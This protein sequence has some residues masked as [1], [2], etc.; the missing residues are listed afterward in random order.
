MLRSYGIPF[1]VVVTS[2]ITASTFWDSTNHIN[3]YQFAVLFGANSI[4]DEGTYSP[5]VTSA[6]TAAASNGTNFIF[7]GASITQ[8]GN[9]FFGFTSYLECPTHA[10]A[11]GSCGAETA[12]KVKVNSTFA[13]PTRGDPT[14][15]SGTGTTGVNVPSISVLAAR[16]RAPSAGVKYF[17]TYSVNGTTYPLAIFKKFGSSPAM[18][19]WFGG[20]EGAFTGEFPGWS[21]MF[22][23]NLA[24]NG[25][26]LFKP[27]I[28]LFQ[29][30][31]NNVTIANSPRMMAWGT[32]GSAEVIRISDHL[33]LT[34]AACNNTGS[35]VTQQMIRNNLPGELDFNLNGISSSVIT[36]ISSTTPVGVTNPQGTAGFRYWG[37]MGG[38][39]TG[40]SNE[41]ELTAVVDNMTATTN[42]GVGDTGSHT[43]TV[44]INDGNT[45][46][47]QKIEVLVTATS[48]PSWTLAFKDSKGNTLWTSPSQTTT[49]SAPTWVKFNDINFSGGLTGYVN[50]LQG[51]DKLVLTASS[52]TVKWENQSS[53]Q[54]NW[55]VTGRSNWD[56][57]YED[58]SGS[59]NFA[60][61]SALVPDSIRMAG[62]SL[63]HSQNKT[64]YFSSIPG[65]VH[66][67]DIAGEKSNI[68]LYRGTTT[69]GTTSTVLQDA[70]ASWTTNQYAGGVLTYTSGPASGQ[71]AAIS[72]NTANTVTTQA[73]GST[74]DSSGDTFLITSP[75]GVNFETFFTPADWSSHRGQLVIQSCK[76]LAQTYHWSIIANGWTHAKT[77]EGSYDN[78]WYMGNGSQAST[79]LKVERYND[80]VSYFNKEFGTN[81]G[82][83][84][85]AYPVPQWNAEWAFGTSEGSVAPGFQELSNGGIFY[86][87]QDAEQTNGEQYGGYNRQSTTPSVCTSVS[88]TPYTGNMLAVPLRDGGKA[89]NMTWAIGYNVTRESNSIVET[90]ADWNYVSSDY[91]L[92]KSQK[93]TQPYDIAS[94]VWTTNYA[95]AKYWNATLDAMID[96]TTFQWSSSTDTITLVTNTG[97]SYGV[98]NAKWGLP[99]VFRLPES[100]QSLGFTSGTDSQSSGSIT[101]STANWRYYQVNV[102]SGL[103]SFAFTYTEPTTSVTVQTSPTLSNA[104]KV[105]YVT[106][107]SPHTFTYY[108][109]SVHNLIAT[110]PIQCGM[111]CNSVFTSWSDSGAVNHDVTI[112]SGTTYTAAYTRIQNIP[113]GVR[114]VLPINITNAGG[115]SLPVGAQV[116]AIV[117]WSAYSSHES[118]DL[119]NVVIFDSSGKVYTAWNENGTS[120]AAHGV[121]WTKLKSALASSAKLELFAGFYSVGV[122]NYSPTG[123][124]GEAPQLSATYG[125]Y[126]NGA[127]VFNLYENFAGT[128]CPAGWTCGGSTAINNGATVSY[129]GNLVTSASYGLNASQI[130]EFNAN[131]PTPTTANTLVGYTDGTSGLATNPVMGFV[132]NNAYSGTG[133]VAAASRVGFGVDHLASPAANGQHIWTVYWPDGSDGTW[134][135]D[136]LNSNSISG[137]SVVQNTALPI[138]VANNQN[139]NPAPMITYMRLQYYSTTTTTLGSVTEVFVLTTAAGAGGTTV[140]APGLNFYTSGSAVVVAGNPS[141]GYAFNTWTCSGAGCVSGS[142]NP[143][144]VAMN[145]NITETA[146]F[147]GTAPATLSLD[148]S[149]STGVNSGTTASVSLTTSCSPDVVVVL[150]GENSARAI[151]TAA[152]PTAPGLTFTQRTSLRSSTM[153]EWEYYAIA[154]GPLASQTITEVMSQQTV[155]TMTAF[156][157][158]GANTATPFDSNPQLPGTLGGLWSAFHS[159]SVT[160]SGSNDFIFDIDASQGNPSYTPLNG[161]TPVLT[162]EVTSWMA[163]STEYKVVSSAQSG[164]TLGFALSVGQSGSQIVDA[165]V[166]ASTAGVAGTPPPGL[167][168]TWTNLMLAGVPSS[169]NLPS[170]AYDSIP[171]RF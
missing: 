102:G 124:W 72:S 108:V 106:Y 160:T 119:R 82:T 40:T 26:T 52:G 94:T 69:S 31:L 136:Y 68:D 88:C 41:Y 17:M 143:I 8:L 159:N 130:L 100:F 131:L 113:A 120:S 3:K 145:N 23:S 87:F 140:P 83:M 126:D 21:Y 97:T 22:Q 165:I 168:L 105:D 24:G 74:P 117:P 149:A 122:N 111:L 110:S 164:T 64:T 55:V 73:F 33:S 138:G 28:D 103:T 92:A 118:P 155:F 36:A 167:V 5:A 54:A 133:Y 38:G 127:Q 18:V 99:I 134:S 39:A 56:I 62:G 142:S 47:I 157:V 169:R 66:P 12:F 78:D 162:Q 154:T 109:N 53:T 147:T 80:M 171:S 1:D 34:S 50:N 148:G 43:S 2:S 95:A 14:Y 144:A 19:W 96:A 163:S 16:P 137:S 20:V 32:D 98:N 129:S 86:V 123:S 77:A 59:K 67:A 116:K 107:L 30:A 58:A 57:V 115:S 84:T 75:A 91:L 166:S 7:M 81:F 51:N 60:S 4:D 9:A 44:T 37:T 114:W 70:S 29:Y 121:V 156:G 128:S 104:I 125:Q 10:Q 93:W 89:L 90:P 146:S 15:A 132:G 85:S 141:G 42:G 6:I 101:N 25:G 170:P 49:F 152:T 135:I 13:G 65:E 45:T 27:V 151:A 61:A 112:L 139:A 35:S 150:L 63:Y 76:A 158:C 161:Y 71:R 46:Q 48:T 153:W 79:A 11:G